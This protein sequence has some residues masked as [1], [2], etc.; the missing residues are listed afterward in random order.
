MGIKNLLGYYDSN[1]AF[2]VRKIIENEYLVKNWISNK[3]NIYYLGSS[4]GCGCGWISDCGDEEDE[5]SLKKKTK[6]R[7]QLH[8]LLN[9]KDFSGSHLIACWEGKQGKELERFESLNIFNI[10]D[11][12]F[13]FEECVDYFIE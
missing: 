6:D 12:K 11:V 10:L 7:D 5:E 2:W 1:P 4:Q 3:A 8:Q 9:S 13:E